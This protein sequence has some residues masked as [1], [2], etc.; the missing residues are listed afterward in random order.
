MNVSV[1]DG[2]FVSFGVV[3]VTVS[4]I[5][6]DMLKNSVTI[7]VSHLTPED[8][9]ISYRRKFM[10]T[11][12]NIFSVRMKDIEVISIQPAY[13]DS[14]MQKRQIRQDLDVV[15]AIRQDHMSFYEPGTVR[16]LLKDNIGK[17]EA[18]TRLDIVKVIDDRCELTTCNHGKCIDRLILDESVVISITTD[19]S[20]FV[21]PQHHQRLECD[22]DPGYGGINMIF[23]IFSSYHVCFAYAQGVSHSSQI[24]SGLKVCSPKILNHHHLLQSS[25]S[26][27]V[28][29]GPNISTT[30]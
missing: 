13:D 29:N 12:K 24:V 16:R 25:P 18:G 17:L 20:S 9:I 15:I 14:R 26:G 5:T 10:R 19:D 8:F 11:L 4:M 23:R 22:C 27:N 1:T 28:H 3:A 7:R 6:D 30:I 21:S 2:K